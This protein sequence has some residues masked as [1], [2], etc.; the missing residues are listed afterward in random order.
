MEAIQ[1]G[2]VERRGKGEIFGGGGGMGVV[3]ANCPPSTRIHPP[4]SGE[5]VR[6]DNLLKDIPNWDC[7]GSAVVELQYDV[8]H[9]LCTSST[10]DKILI[11]F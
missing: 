9:H 11:Y 5:S 4:K 10:D 1:G 3:F 8:R 6:R 7:L 2:G